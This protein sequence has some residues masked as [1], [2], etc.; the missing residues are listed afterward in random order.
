MQF[1]RFNCRASLENFVYLTPDL[2]VYFS[3]R[4]EGMK[5]CA[6]CGRS[7]GYGRHL[8]TMGRNW[9]PNC[10]CCGSCD[11]AI[12]DREFSV[13]EDV[14]YHRECYKK[15]FHPK[16]QICH[17]FVSCNITPLLKSSN[18]LLFFYFIRCQVKV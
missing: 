17:N 12:V 7:L 15:S 18:E 3:D 11:R 16:C 5:I 1:Q 2:G 8:T 9:H 13:Q 10:F 4:F 6:G 14:P